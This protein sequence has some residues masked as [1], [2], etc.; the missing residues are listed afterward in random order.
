MEEDVEVRSPCF[1]WEL[2][3][4][5]LPQTL[6]DLAVAAVPVPDLNIVILA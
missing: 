3:S 4:L 6:D 2:A 5:S 1:G